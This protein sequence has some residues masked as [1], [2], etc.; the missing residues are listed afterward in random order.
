M[1]SHPRLA[2]PPAWA[3]RLIA[4]LPLLLVTALSLSLLWPAPTGRMPLS[5]DHTVHL[6]RIWMFA[7][8]LATGQ[9]RGWS[10]T[11]F[12]GTPVGELYPVLGDL[13]IVALRALSFG[14]LTWPQS[15][16]LGFSL[17][18][19]M[20]G[21]ALLRVGRALGLGP[22]PGLV[23]ALLVLAD[24]GAYREGG[25][26]YTVVYGV[27]PQALS[28]ALTWLALSELSIACETDDPIIRRRR[29]ATTALAMGG[30][31]L[32]HPMA[33]LSFAIGGPLLIL[34]L[35]MRSHATLKR[36]TAVATI[37]ALL[38][39]SVAAWWIVPMLQHRAWMAS[40]GWMWLPLERMAAMAAEGQ[41]TQAM[42]TAVGAAAGLGLVLLAIVGS[43][44]ARFVAAFALLSWLLASRDT[45]WTLRLDQLSEGFAHLQYQRFLITAKP[46]LFLA[47]GAALALLVRGASAAWTRLRPAAGRPLALVLAASALGLGSWMAIGQRDA[48]RDHHVGE[49]QLERV[50]GEPTFDAEYAALLEW[51]RSQP[52][53]EAPPYRTTV[54]AAR[55]LHWFMDAPALTGMRLYKQGFTPGDNFVHKPEAGPTELLDALRVRY[56]ITTGR[57]GPRRAR[58]VAHFGRIRVFERAEWEQ[59]PIAWLQGPGSLEVLED[60][61]EGGRVRVQISGSGE[62]TRVVFGIAGFPRWALHAGDEPIEWIEVPVLGDGPAATQA[63]RRAGMLR[64]GKAHGDDGSEPTLIAADV[65]DGELELR[66]HPRRPTDIAAGFVSVLALGLCGLL[67]WKP[68]R[69]SG[70]TRYLDAAVT[71]LAL[72]GHPAVIGGLA[73]ILAIGAAVRR[74]QADDL[75][76][77][78]AFG[79]VEEGRARP[80][81]H[82]HAGLFKT[83]M[84]IQPAVLVD[85]RRRA[86]A[87]IVFPGVALADSLTGWVAIDDDAAKMRRKGR[88]RLRIEALTTDG[89][90]T[91]LHETW[92]AHRPGRHVLKLDTSALAGQRV[93]LRVVIESEG[94]SP[95]PL[96]FD[97]DLGSKGGES[98]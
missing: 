79:W 63:E 20:Q 41:W 9:V 94:K 51:M 65:H 8:Q 93:D 29:V 86:P 83:D 36:T 16:A 73:L 35:G 26:M 48:A 10:T 74:G 24:V 2:D 61:V 60:D 27:W 80:G 92:L 68:Q 38:G 87:V 58:E 67:L 3:R 75:E 82:A 96:G 18:F 78:K 13:V 21:W 72:L 7:E 19:T 66:Y 53:D 54:L 95:P 50:P 34:T 43:R 32:A 30:A 90:T 39:L 76:R 91:L 25:W 55:N 11:W 59:Q 37:A 22:L 49:L 4:A 1:G 88:H 62:G 56:V 84:L 57:R 17:V 64:G 98:P 42:P 14:T 6:T 5:A 85:P 52:Q 28:T 77:T 33:M 71:R 47:A 44:P 23:A 45:L 40:Y 70:P 46:G 89:G 31:L 15:Y 12:F 69:W 81:P 97:L